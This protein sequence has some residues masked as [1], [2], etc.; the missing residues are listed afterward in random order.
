MIDEAFIDQILKKGKEAKNKANSAFS[1]ITLEQLN[2]QPSNV[3]WSI[4]QCLDHLIVSHSIYFPDLEKITKGIFRM[5]FW[6]KY[7]PFTRLCGSLMKDRMKEQ[8][9]KKMIAPKKIQPKT[10][11]TLEIIEQYHKSLDIFLVYIS[12]CRN[13][14]IDKTIIGS[15]IFSIVTYSLKDAFEFLITHEHRHINQAIRVK[16]NEKFGKNI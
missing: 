16:E 3:S 10:N 8:V 4:A 2:W 1:D 7:S 5:S 9:K 14:D 13:T 12:N 15:P 6:Q 11:A